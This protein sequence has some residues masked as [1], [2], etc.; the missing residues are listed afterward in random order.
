MTGPLDGIRVLDFTT[1]FSGPFC[2]LS[3]ADLGAD[4]IKVE[5][6]GGDITRGLG[7]ARVPGMTSIFIAGNRGKASVE[8][9]LKDDRA[10]ATVE[11]LIGKAD[12][13]VHNMRLPAAERVGIDPGRACA[14]NPR[15]VHASI[16]GF[17]SDGPYAG[18]PAYDDSIQAASGLAWLQSLSAPAPAYIA[19]VIADKVAGMATANAI[20]AA[21]FDRER[22][23]LGQSIEVPMF[24][25]LAGF[26]LMEQWGGRAFV[27]AEGPTGYSRLRAVH[28]R[29]YRTTDGL[30][31][32]VV[33]HAG[34]WQ[35]FF[36]LIGQPE[37]LEDERYKTVQARSE[38]I[39]ELYALV[40]RVIAT[41]STAQ[42]L[43]A[44]A[45]IDVPAM[46]VVSLDALF[47]DEHLNAVNFFRTV[48]AVD[49]DTYL[50]A[51]PSAKFSRT[52]L[53]DPAELGPPQPLGVG[54]DAVARWLG[55]DPE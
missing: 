15:L 53:E 28:R 46:P 44:L 50:V 30:I 55:D 32:V 14:I 13:L 34:H 21:L 9:D 1:T 10:L 43:T 54:K 41:R 5:A 47:D 49:G 42:W 51:R 45:E 37:L 26:A 6:P 16:T 8:L 52:P 35:R 7:T 25:T 12:C 31:A 24:E 27:P 17:G 36:N 23:G 3:L 19:T 22:T 29:P 33:Y 11:R 4:V 2:T 18:R 20:L 38:H 39:D 40:E 48:D